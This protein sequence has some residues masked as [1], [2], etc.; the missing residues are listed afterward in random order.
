VCL[1]PYHTIPY[2]TIQY[3]TSFLKRDVKDKFYW[4]KNTRKQ[5]STLEWRSQCGLHIV[6]QACLFAEI[7][8]QRSFTKILKHTLELA[9]FGEQVE[10]EVWMER[11]ELED[12]IEEPREC[13][14]WQVDW[15]ERLE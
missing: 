6:V 8:L 13:V 14:E 12:D 3:H 5:E 4:I 11:R 7:T 15:M 2:H 9:E 10:S 1:A